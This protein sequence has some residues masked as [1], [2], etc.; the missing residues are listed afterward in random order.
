MFNSKERYVKRSAKELAYRFS[1]YR[2]S[3][4]SREYYNLTRKDMVDTDMAD[5]KGKVEDNIQ[6]RDLEPTMLQQPDHL[7]SLSQVRVRVFR[8]RIQSQVCQIQSLVFQ[9]L[10]IRILGVFFDNR[11]SKQFLLYCSYSIK[12]MHY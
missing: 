12:D 6:I 10:Q 4:E 7:R 3:K 11:R 9:I 1:Y 5:S 2:F 8:I